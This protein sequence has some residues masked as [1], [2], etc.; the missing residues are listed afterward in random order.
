MKIK[1]I[2]NTK[3]ETVESH[4]RLRSAARKMKELNI[5]SMLVVDDGKLCGFITDRDISVYAIAMGYGSE[6]TDVKQVMNTEVVTCFADQ[7]INEA[8]QIMQQQNIRR[9]VVLDKDYVLEGILSVD[10]I[11]RVSHDLAGAVLEAATTSH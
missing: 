6:S 2:M 1:D 9:L 11:A 10:D 7:D 4:N 8:A 3:V 5:G